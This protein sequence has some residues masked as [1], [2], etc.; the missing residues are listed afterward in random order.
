MS[1]E[2]QHTS[3][4]ISNEYQ[5]LPSLPLGVMPTSTSDPPAPQSPTEHTDTVPSSQAPVVETS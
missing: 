3:S 2:T 5:T 1:D 4:A